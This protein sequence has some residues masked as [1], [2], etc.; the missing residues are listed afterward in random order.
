LQYEHSRHPFVMA[1]FSL[2]IFFFFLLLVIWGLDFR[3]RYRN[4]LLCQVYVSIRIHL[5]AADPRLSDT[6][7]SGAKLVTA[8][9]IW[10]VGARFA[11]TLGAKKISTH[12][13]GARPPFGQ[14]LH[15][16]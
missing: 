13:S 14:F 6:I 2:P 1:A 16:W 4:C 9:L 11:A 5:S 15:R 3:P 8:T 7:L 10:K 12:Y